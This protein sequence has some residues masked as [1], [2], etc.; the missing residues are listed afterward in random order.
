M[1]EFWEFIALGYDDYNGNPLQPHFEIQG[2]NKE[3]FKAWLK[4]FHTVV[5]TLYTPST[6]EYFKIKSNDIA[7]NF[8]RRLSLGK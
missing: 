2:I 7:E 6:G 4:L 1:I 3:A 5:D 8:I